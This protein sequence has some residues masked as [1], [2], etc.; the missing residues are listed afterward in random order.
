MLTSG[1]A[2]DYRQITAE[3]LARQTPNRFDVVTCM[4]L[5]EHVPRPASILDACARLVKPGGNLFYAT[6]NRTWISRLLVI[7]MSEYVL[8][9]VR[10]GTH[11]YHKLVTPDELKRWGMAAG[12]DFVNLS[13]L[14]YIPFFGYASLCRSTSM[15]FMMHFNRSK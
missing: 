8:G 10:K 3:E 12:L 1:L 5:L 7:F 14:R 13:G 9:I 4:E 11:D 15:N 2:I 6:V